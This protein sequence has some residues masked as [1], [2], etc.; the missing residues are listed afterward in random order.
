MPRPL[1]GL[2]DGPRVERGERDDPL[3]ELLEGGEGGRHRLCDGGRL[4]RDERQHARLLD[5]V[6]IHEPHQHLGRPVLA[7][8]EG[9]KVRV[10]VDVLRLRRTAGSGP[11][12]LRAGDGRAGSGCQEAAA[13]ESGVNRSLSKMCHERF[14]GDGIDGAELRRRGPPGQAGSARALEYIL[15]CALCLSISVMPGK[16][17]PESQKAFLTGA[18]RGSRA[19][20]T[21]GEKARVTCCIG[22]VIR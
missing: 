4:G 22:R 15:Q 8:I 6:L 10:D 1:A 3:G 14:Q 16:S 2:G 12:G 18:S 20:T 19:K 21:R 5:V 7:G 17:N 9:P 13:G 11:G